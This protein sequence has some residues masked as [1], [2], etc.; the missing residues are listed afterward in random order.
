MQEMEWVGYRNRFLTLVRTPEE[1]DR[2]HG[3]WVH[4]LAR[5]ARLP[6]VIFEVL[7][8]KPSLVPSGDSEGSEAAKDTGVP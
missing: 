4:A 2:P 1:T 8:S 7:R 5:V 6:N 3:V